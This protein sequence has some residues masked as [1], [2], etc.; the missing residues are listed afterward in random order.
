MQKLVSIDGTSLCELEELND[1]Y[2]SNGWNIK[3]ML[4][5]KDD[6]I[7]ILLEKDTRKEKLEKLN[8]ISTH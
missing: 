5:M 8:D 1:D 7:I 2:L 3:K 6:E 4:R